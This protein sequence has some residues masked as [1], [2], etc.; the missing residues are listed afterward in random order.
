MC[1]RYA[2]ARHPGDLADSF[3]AVDATEGRCLPA[4]YNVAPTKEVHAVLV[5]HGVRQLRVLRWGLVPSWAPDVSGGARLINARI[6]TVAGKPA[7]RSA[8]LRRRCLVP[9]DGWYEWAPATDRP[10]RQP[11][12]VTPADGSL[13]AFAGLYEVRDGLL[14]ATII[15]TA[16]AGP[17]TALH[18]RMPVLLDRAR[19][20]DWLAPEA[21]PPDLAA[22]ATGSGLQVRAVGA[23]VGNVNNNGPALTAPRLE[24]V[25][26]PV[27]QTL[28]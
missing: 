11:Y 7:F 12:F 19:W 25:P 4:D 2:S 15:T 24:P 22:S 21:D 26:V 27:P 17:L 8:W 6:E 14:T 16:A 18:D 13:L 9:A 20:A 5:R 3:D 10:G 23:A 1:G 28:F